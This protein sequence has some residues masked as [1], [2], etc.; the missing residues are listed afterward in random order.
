M[1]L[2]SLHTNEQLTPTFVVHA[3]EQPRRYSHTNGS[4]SSTSN[5][6][7]LA[8]LLKVH[9]VQAPSTACAV[10]MTCSSPHKTYRLFHGASH[11][12]A[13]LLRSTGSTSRTTGTTCAGSHTVMLV[14]HM[15]TC[16]HDA[17][18]C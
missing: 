16:M 10:V 15:Q 3:F 2:L 18:G 14:D 7:P 12:R 8:T 13:G 11:P 9:A 6:P 5:V 17:V 1:L 4:A